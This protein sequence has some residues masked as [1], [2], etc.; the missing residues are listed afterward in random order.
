MLPFQNSIDGNICFICYL[1]EEFSLIHIKDWQ[2]C[3]V[4][5]VYNWIQKQH[6]PI[7]RTDMVWHKWRARL[8]LISLNNNPF[9]KQL[10]RLHWWRLYCLCS[11]A[12]NIYI[13]I[14]KYRLLIVLI[15]CMF[16]SVEVSMKWV[17]FAY[18]D[19]K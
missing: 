2:S 18:H 11:Q 3:A 1:N 9:T 4:E 19:M 14:C 10:S 17:I 6:T 8:P 5:F 12:L 16:G 15:F 7:L 13:N